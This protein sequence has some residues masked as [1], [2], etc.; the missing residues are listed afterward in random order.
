[1]DAGS[2]VFPPP[3]PTCRL[4]WIPVRWGLGFIL[5]PVLKYI[6]TFSFTNRHVVGSICAPPCSQCGETTGNMGACW[7]ED[8]D[9]LVNPAPA[10]LIVAEA[11]REEYVLFCANFSTHGRDRLGDGPF[12][13]FVRTD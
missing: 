5:N 3:L 1:M 13:Y 9:A 11:T 10:L 8:C 2:G 12:Y 6:S 4:S 7:G